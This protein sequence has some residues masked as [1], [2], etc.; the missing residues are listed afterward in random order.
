MAIPVDS[1]QQTQDPGLVLGVMC[2][3]TA[4]LSYLLQTTW[5]VGYTDF[6]TFI[7]PILPWLLNVVLLLR[8][9]SHAPK[10]YWWVLPT[11]IIANPTFLIICIMMLAWS[12]GG[13]V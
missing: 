11:V 3:L 12:L 13:F 5:R 10:R 7:I 4:T 1:T 8:Y 9:R 6:E 2:Y